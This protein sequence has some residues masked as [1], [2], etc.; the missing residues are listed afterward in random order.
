VPDSYKIL[1]VPDPRMPPFSDYLQTCN[2][3]Q[4]QYIIGGVLRDI[5]Q[6]FSLVSMRAC[7]I[8]DATV[9]DR[10][11]RFQ[12]CR[13]GFA[14]GPSLITPVIPASQTVF[15][16]L[17]SILH[18]VTAVI[19]GNYLS[20]FSPDSIFAHG[21]LDDGYYIKIDVG[22]AAVAGDTLEVYA[23]FKYMNRLWNIPI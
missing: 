12:V 11:I 16:Q 14:V 1:Q 21:S 5:P 20:G 23:Q 2:G 3:I 6:I 13:R 19:T 9:G 7:L 4:I 17:N 18:L 15:W 22:G 8:T 10:T